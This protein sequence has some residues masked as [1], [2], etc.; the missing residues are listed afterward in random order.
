MTEILIWEAKGGK[1]S[2][3]QSVEK[4]PEYFYQFALSRRGTIEKF[5]KLG[6]EFV[7]QHGLD[8]L[9]GLKDEIDFLKVS[10]QRIYDSYIF[11]G[12]VTKKIWDKIFSNRCSHSCLLVLKRK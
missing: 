11:F 3:W 1:Y 4:D 2:L 8:E 12:R 10:F 7:G 9:K 6:F 5:R